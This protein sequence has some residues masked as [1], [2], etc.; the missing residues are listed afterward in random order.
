MRIGSISTRCS[1][2]SAWGAQ[3]AVVALA[4][5]HQALADVGAG[6]DVHAQAVGR[7]LVHEAP[8]GAGE[9]AL[10]GLAHGVHIVE[11]AVA[12]LEQDL[13]G[14]GAQAG[15][16]RVEQRGLA[17]AGF[18]DDGQHLAGPEFERGLVQSDL[19]AV[20]FADALCAQQGGGRSGHG[21]VTKLMPWR[22]KPSDS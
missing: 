19:L 21:V 3:V 12:A 7:L 10:L 6:R 16:E 1:H 18:A 15:G 9:Q 11:P 22:W 4:Q 14:V 8:V 17:R 2:S 13:S 20:A 5:A